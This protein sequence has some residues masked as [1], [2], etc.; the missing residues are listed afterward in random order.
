MKHHRKFPEFIAIFAAA[1]ALA[2]GPAVAATIPV[3]GGCS[4]IH[5]IQSANGDL[6][7]G[8]CVAGSGHDTILLQSNID[9][10]GAFSGF[11]ALP[12]L[13]SDMTI[14]GQG[15]YTLRITG[16]AAS[17][18]FFNHDAGTVTLRGITFR[19]GRM[20]G[21]GQG[22]AFTANS[23]ATMIVEECEFINNVAAQ[24]GAFTFGPSS[25]F[26]GSLT[27]RDSR[28]ENNT[29]HG[30]AGGAISSQTTH[31]DV[32]IQR[33]VFVGNT[34]PN[35]VG[36][37]FARGP[38]GTAVFEDCEFTDN[39]ALQGG[40][41]YF[42]GSAPG[43]VVNIWR[44][45][46]SSNSADKGGAIGLNGARTLFIRESTLDSNTATTWGGAIWADGGGAG[47]FVETINTTL[48]GNSAGSR[49]GAIYVGHFP[50]VLR[51]STV[52]DNSAPQGAGFYGFG[53]PGDLYAYWS[54]L[55]NAANGANCQFNGA[56]LFDFGG[57]LVDDGTCGGTVGPITG[58]DPVLADNGG[59]TLTHALLAG[60]NAIDSAPTCTLP[61]DQRGM[62]RDD[63]A[64]DSGAYE[65]EAT[66][67]PPPVPDGVSGAPLLF[68][69]TNLAG[70]AIDV[71]WDASCNAPDY[72]LLHGDLADVE[73]LTPDDSS[74]AL[75]TSGTASGLPVSAGDRWF[76]LVAND[77]ADLEGSWGESSGGT[78]KPGVPSLE[79]G[80]VDRNDAGVCP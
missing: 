2:G 30:G 74:C 32:T 37:A 31:H 40:A 41:I 52:I 76:L 69:R 70:T 67:F 33:T 34:S 28:F 66:Y 57:N 35:S 65:F 9:M 42:G 49:G 51:S 61:T 58:L 78:R 45:S 1:L 6:P 54:L 53:G 22:G 15:L 47:G 72:H 16:G 77:A 68:D 46:F 50:G 56:S 64:C 60:S 14:D 4:L 19:D 7:V 62:A 3:G 17:L 75:G 27:V 21:S 24:G 38:V 55:A 8:G 12:K 10:S 59:P 44:S 36:G 13:A 26:A 80:I 23:N 29:A 39:S 11:N 63:G 48:S 43:N 71:Y 20:A 5:A 73:L 79:C 25:P 18:R